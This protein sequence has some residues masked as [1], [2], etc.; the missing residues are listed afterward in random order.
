MIKRKDG[1]WR[2]TVKLP[3]MSKPKYFYGNK[4]DTDKAQQRDIKRQ[5]ALWTDRQ[6][7]GVSFAFAADEWDNWHTEQVTYNAA[8][9]YVTPLKMAKAQFEGR[10]IKDIGPDEIDA[11][12]R[13]V[14]GRGYARRT[15][16][17]HL[18]MLRMI[19]DYAVVHR[20]R[21]DNPCGSVRIPG[22][23]PKGTREIPTEDELERVAAAKDIEFGLF[24]FMLMYTG[25]RRG[26]LLALR[27]SD[28]DLER[29]IIK[30]ER[31]IYYDINEPKIKDP[32]T[33]AGRREVVLLDVL[34]QALP[35]PGAGYIFGGKK[36]LTKSSFDKRWRQWCIQA[37]FAEPEYFTNRGK[38]GKDY[39]RTKWK[40]T[41]TPHQLRHAFA[42]TLFDAGIDVKDA[43][44]IL[45][46]ASIAVTR[47]IYTHITKKRKSATADKLNAF[48]GQNS[49]KNPQ[50]P[51]NKGEVTTF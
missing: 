16:Q 10:S 6:I 33:E 24:P 14:A 17:A 41:L 30:V 18:D 49:V 19:F 11:Y 20:W 47:D 38:D 37:G 5:I 25:L 44:D 48:L 4:N 13:F 43:Q 15:V 50:T 29:R 7:A 21:N 32:K 23:L 2:E 51:E 34:A 3:G 40:T 9:Y 12:I 27:W 46:H 22:N 39:R 1:R 28:I 26:E 35:K 42:T 8:K 36:P 31:S 45:G